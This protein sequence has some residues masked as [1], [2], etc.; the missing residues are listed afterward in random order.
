M[1][2]YTVKSMKLRNITELDLSTIGIAMI[3]IGT[4]LVASTSWQAALGVLILLGAV[5]VLHYSADEKRRR[6]KH[7]TR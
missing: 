4:F 5:D 6:N 2:R 3:L 7:G 1:S